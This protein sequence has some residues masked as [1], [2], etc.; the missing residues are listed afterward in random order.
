MDNVCGILLPKFNYKDDKILHIF[1]NNII[2]IKYYNK[3]YKL[4]FYHKFQKN[5]LKI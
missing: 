3:F 5:I 4:Y 1:T 2:N